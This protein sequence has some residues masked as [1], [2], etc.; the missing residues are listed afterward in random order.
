MFWVIARKNIFIRVLCSTNPHMSSFGRVIEI[1]LYTRPSLWFSCNA[2]GCPQ[3]QIE[4]YDHEVLFKGGGGGGGVGNGRHALTHSLLYTLYLSLSFTHTHTHTRIH[5]P[6]GL[7]W[8]YVVNMGEFNVRTLMHDQHQ[9]T[10]N[11]RREGGRDG[12]MVVR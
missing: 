8:R 3:R 7:P 1:S 2:F 11:E 4:L 10:L 6:H 9:L 12:W 5:S